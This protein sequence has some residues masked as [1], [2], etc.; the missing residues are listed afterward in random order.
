MLLIYIL[1]AIVVVNRCHG[2]RRS[3]ADIHRG[4]ANHVGSIAAAIDVADDAQLVGVVRSVKS[5]G[6][7]DSRHAY[8]VDIGKSA[9]YHV[10]VHRRVGIHRGSRT[11]AAAEHLADVGARDNVQLGLGVGEGVSGVSVTVSNCRMCV[12][13]RCP[14][15]QGARIVVVAVHRIGRL[16]AAEVEL[17]DGDRR[18]AVARLLNVQLDV[19]QDGA[20]L[21]VAAEHLAEVAAGDGQL[22]VAADVGIVG[23]GIEHR[24]FGAGLTAHDHDEV[25]VDVGILAR[26]HNL[27]HVEG[28]FAAGAGVDGH[29]AGDGAFPVTATVGLVHVAALQQRVGVAVDVGT[30]V[31]HPGGAAV[32]G[33]FVASV[34]AAE[35][36]FD[37]VGTLHQHVGLRHRC[38]VAAAVDI[39]HADVAGLYDDV[40]L[41]SRC[42]VAGQVAAAIDG[43]HLVVVSHVVGLVGYSRVFW[44]FG[45]PRHVA[46][47]RL[48]Y[49]H[50][51]AA[52]R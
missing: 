20:A 27:A 46:R 2:D 33:V 42:R 17:V 44:V 5:L 3:R 18:F 34:T 28:T 23:T 51:H 32:G 6:G 10:D 26:A 48:P 47:H 4:I 45:S 22:H 1:S 11:I 9:W 38:R 24:H 13:S 29:V 36:L 25:A 15:L 52:L 49:I 16:V 37:L 31:G 41:L 39:L 14:G 50:L 19:S 21:V 7:H 35:Q 12:S 40:R 30:R 8:G 43:R